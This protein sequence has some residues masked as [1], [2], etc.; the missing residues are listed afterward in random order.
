MWL[1][2]DMHAPMPPLGDRRWFRDSVGGLPQWKK[3]DP[4]PSVRLP[5]GTQSPPKDWLKWVR[6]WSERSLG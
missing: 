6:R 4:V 5:W 1:R 2:V 3:I